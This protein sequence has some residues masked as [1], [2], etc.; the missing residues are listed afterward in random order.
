MD[1]ETQKVLMIK[2]IWN[3]AFTHH[4]CY[5]CENMVNWSSLVFEIWAFLQLKCELRFGTQFAIQ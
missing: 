4:P 5:I 3:S 1:V 2:L